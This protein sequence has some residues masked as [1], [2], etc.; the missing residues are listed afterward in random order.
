MNIIKSSF[1]L[2]L[3]LTMTLSSLVARAENV[4]C[5]ASIMDVEEGS[6]EVISSTPLP[7]PT[8][9]A[10]GQTL[11]NEILMEIGKLEDLLLILSINSNE[12]AI[13]SNNSAYHLQLDAISN[14]QQIRKRLLSVPLPVLGTV[15]A[16]YSTLNSMH[17]VRVWCT[18]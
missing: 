17:R 4:Y 15:H 10:D 6:V 16:S 2:C 8:S 18:R 1:A 14:S 7:L 13:D 11:T 9:M 5:G 12:K 3:S